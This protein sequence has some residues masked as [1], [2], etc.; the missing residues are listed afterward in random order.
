MQ[1]VATIKSRMT[2]IEAGRKTAWG[3]D[4]RPSD[5]YPNILDDAVPDGADESDNV[6]VRSHGDKPEFAFTPKDHVDLGENLG[7]MDFTA[8]AKLSGARFVVLKNGLA[9][10]E[11][12]LVYA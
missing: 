1:E 9:R 4:Q 12:A 11:R 10:L 3:K 8:G 7:M 5:G 2:D 6:L